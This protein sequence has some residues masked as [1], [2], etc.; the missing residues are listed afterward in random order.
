RIATATTLRLPATLVFDYPDPTT[1]AHHLHTE[2]LPEEVT[3]AVDDE[4]AELRKTLQSIPLTRI[5]EAGLLSLLLELANPG[6]SELGKKP[7]EEQT[8]AIK[9]MGVDELLAAAQRTVQ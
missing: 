7:A 8:A 5:R 9:S 4:E 2:L 1:L 6:G 3:S